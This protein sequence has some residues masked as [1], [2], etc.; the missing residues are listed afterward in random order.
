MLLSTVSVLQYCVQVPLHALGLVT[1]LR[2]EFEVLI[3]LT[4]VV[5]PSHLLF[6]YGVLVN[7]HRVAKI[8]LSRLP[9]D[10]Y[11]PLRRWIYSWMMRLQ[12]HELLLVSNL[13]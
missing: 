10:L 5:F 4:K 12:V 13:L 6:E 3:L 8:T 7:A 2:V 11:D 1:D 9:L